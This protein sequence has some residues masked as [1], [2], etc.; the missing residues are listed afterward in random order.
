M[1]TQAQKHKSCFVIFLCFFLY[2]RLRCYSSS[3]SSRTGKNDLF[4]EACQ[5]VCLGS[6]LQQ[7]LQSKTRFSSGGQ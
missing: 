1:S 2:V 7:S 3:S 5:T 6:S 4:S